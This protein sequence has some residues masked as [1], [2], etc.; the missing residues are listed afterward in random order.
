[1]LRM[2]H[3][4]YFFLILKIVAGMIFF[5]NHQSTYPHIMWVGKN[6]YLRKKSFPPQF[7]ELRIFLDYGTF[8]IY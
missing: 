6:D 3:N 8:Q 4:K 1:M 5:L 2:Y 7:L